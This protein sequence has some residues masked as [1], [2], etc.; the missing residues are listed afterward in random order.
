MKGYNADE[1]VRIRVPVDHINRMRAFIE[2]Y[3]Q[4]ALRDGR[5]G[6]AT[7][8][9]DLWI[10]ALA[11]GVEATKA[12]VYQ[13]HPGLRAINEL[14][15]RTADRQKPPQKQPPRPRK[16]KP[17]AIDPGQMSGPHPDTKRTHGGPDS[18]AVA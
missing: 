12:F 8:T 17:A 15:E 10:A 9:R 1:M 7:F 5:S 11:A 18:T 13:N 14:L 4:G 3:E 16:P 2:E 6:M